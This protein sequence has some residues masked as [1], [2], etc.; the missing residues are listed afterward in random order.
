[1]AESETHIEINDLTMAYGDRIIQENLNFNINRGDI[2]H[3]L[4]NKY[5]KL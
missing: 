2:L 1:M 5:L 3:N 4:I